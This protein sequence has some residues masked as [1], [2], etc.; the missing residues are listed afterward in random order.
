[1]KIP[2]SRYF[3]PIEFPNYLLEKQNECRNFNL[4]KVKSRLWIWFLLLLMFYTGIHYSI[5]LE[6][7]FKEWTTFE[8]DNNL[9]IQVSKGS[10]MIHSFFAF[11]DC[12]SYVFVIIIDYFFNIFFIEHFHDEICEN[13][14]LL[15]QYKNSKFVKKS[16]PELL[17]I[18]RIRNRLTIEKMV[19]SLNPF[20]HSKNNYD[21]YKYSMKI[22][23][24][25]KI[26]NII[27]CKQNP[28]ITN[29]N[30]FFIIF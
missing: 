28:S 3:D 20:F 14:Q 11:T 1:M 13:N 18:E 15:I 8:I 27:N 26:I 7:N 5:S 16:T 6:N 22:C 24:I 2:F 10:E 9:Y 17:K 19:F 12:F 4:M 23:K 30:N 21:F 25:M 29:F